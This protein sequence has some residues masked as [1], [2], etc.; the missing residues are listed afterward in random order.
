MNGSFQERLPD[1]ED[2]DSLLGGAGPSQQQQHR[3]FH[4]RQQQQPR[5][6]PDL[7]LPGGRGGG[8]AAHGS[9]SNGSMN[10]RH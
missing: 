9:S 6:S 2:E 5:D 4:R 3:Q 7:D 10:G 8:L 1:T